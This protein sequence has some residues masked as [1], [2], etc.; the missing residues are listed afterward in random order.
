MTQITA[1]SSLTIEWDDPLDLGCLPI[2]HYKV[3][4]DGSDLDDEV[5]PGEN[6]FTDS[7]I[8][9]FGIGDTIT[10]RIKTVNYAGESAYSVALVVT[11]GRVP[12]SPSDV[13]VLQ[14]V[15]ETVIELTWTPD[16]PMADNLPTDLYRVYVD[17]LSG[18]DIVP[19]NVSTNLI[20]LDQ[21]LVLGHS[22]EVSVAAVNDI[23]ESD[24]SDDVL[25]LHTGIVPTKLTGISAPHHK[26]SSATEIVIEWLPPAYNGGTPLIEYRVYY[27]VGQTGTLGDSDF[28]SLIPDADGHLS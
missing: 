9:S 5:D 26:S 17:D 12:N 28:E 11:V 8:S 14:R 7:D 3:S 27:D 13:V 20:M 19:Y 2:Y 18:N 10:Y 4:R 16:L 1:F 21:G 22:Y 24:K 15:S 23:G 6:S 25:T